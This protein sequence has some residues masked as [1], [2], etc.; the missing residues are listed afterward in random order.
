[1]SIM[2]SFTTTGVLARVTV[3]RRERSWFRR[4]G[5]PDLIKAGTYLREV[6]HKSMDAIL[7]IEIKL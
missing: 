3:K 4:E 7:F 1:M 5:V 6:K 2:D